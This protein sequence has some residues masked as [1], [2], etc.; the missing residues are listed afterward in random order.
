MHTL[1]QAIKL[2]GLLTTVVFVGF[3]FAYEFVPHPLT[4]FFWDCLLWTVILVSPLPYSIMSYYAH[5]HRLTKVVVFRMA[6]ILL[7]S[8]LVGV[9]AGLIL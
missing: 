2:H 3:C 8:L 9:Y 5:R 1:I 7:I 6:V 4:V